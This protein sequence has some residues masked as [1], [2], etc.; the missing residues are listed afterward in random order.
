MWGRNATAL[1]MRATS[2]VMRGT[3]RKQ[4]RYGAVI[5]AA[6]IALLCVLNVTMAKETGG[7]N[8]IRIA[9][10][11]SEGKPANSPLIR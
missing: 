11:H 3:V 4:R 6:G 9:F 1:A 7:Q 10:L 8:D 2:R 5:V